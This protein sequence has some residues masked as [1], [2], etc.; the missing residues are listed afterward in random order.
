MQ[1]SDQGKKNCNCPGP[2]RFTQKREEEDD[3]TES[4]AKPTTEEGLVCAIRGYISP[5]VLEAFEAAIL[6]FPGPVLA[7]SHNRWF[8]QRFGG[9]RWELEQG[10]LV[11][12]EEQ[13]S[14]LEAL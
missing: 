1:E 14:T 12:R 11:K 8:I 4:P 6:N 3:H 9:I 7:I 13:D 5:D 2:L 10:Q